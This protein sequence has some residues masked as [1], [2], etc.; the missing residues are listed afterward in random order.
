MPGSVNIEWLNQN[1]L[2]AYPLKEDV[3]RVP[4]GLTDVTLPNYVIVDFILTVAGDP[5]VRL[6]LSQLAYVGNLLTFVISDALSSQVATC[7]VNVN[8]HVRNT[9]YN[10][11]GSDEYSDALGRMVVGDL[12]NL[13]RDLAEGLYSFT[14]ATAEFEP[15][16]VRPALR[17]IRSLRISNQGS[18]SDYIYGHVKL[19][20]GTNLQLTY[21][22]EYKADRIDAVDG[23][24]LNQECECGDEI[25]KN[26]IVRLING[27]PI[28]D[29]EIVGDG[30][31]V[32]VKV[33]GNRIVISDICSTPCCGCPELELIT[34][35]LKVLE[36]TVGNLETYSQQ[37]SDRISSFV[38][39]YILT[40]TG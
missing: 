7:T 18:E 14:L 36:A 9:G 32:D 29:V 5:S 26:N 13:S 35:S 39:N 28:E 20:A 3:S 10:I 1:S 30:Q 19:L 6:Y 34:E 8:T 11:V 15:S 4:T 17:A 33:Q 2:R 22:A 12:T 16:T 37:L 25:G 24:W 31:C 21:L 23:G 38:T 27:V 40:I